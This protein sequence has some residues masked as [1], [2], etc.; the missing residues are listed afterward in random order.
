MKL[1]STAHWSSSAARRRGAGWARVRGHG[2][3]GS[4][5]QHPCHP[6]KL[7]WSC[8]P[9]AQP[10]R[11]RPPPSRPC[12]DAPGP[13]QPPPGPSRSPQGQK[14]AWTTILSTQGSNKRVQ[15]LKW[16]A[17]RIELPTSRT[18]SEH[19]TTIPRKRTASCRTVVS[20]WGFHAHITQRVCCSPSR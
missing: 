5:I 16:P 1:G 12:P 7:D 18:L 3:I 20:K 4:R 19:N 13:A 6:V 17:G 2:G 11:P 15:S 14:L 10:S 9:L 8:P